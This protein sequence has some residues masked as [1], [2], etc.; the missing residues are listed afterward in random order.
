[1]AIEHELRDRQ[2]TPWTRRL[3]PVREYVATENASAAILL[4]ATIAA[5]VWANSPWSDSYERLWDTEVSLQ[6]R[7]APS[8][9]STCASGST[10]GSW[11]SSS[12]S[13][14]SRSAASST[15]ASCASGAASPPRCW[16][17]SAAWSLPALIYL[18]INAGE[19]SVAGLGHRH[20][21]RHRL[22]PRRP[23]A[24]GRGRSPGC[25]VP[26][27]VGDRRRHR[28]ADRHRAG[29]HRRPVV[30]RPGR[31]ARALRRRAGDA[32]QP[33]SATASRT[34]WSGSGMWL[35]MLASGVHPTIAGVAVGVLAT[36]YP[37]SRAGPARAGAFWRL[38]REQPTPQ[39]A[40]DRQ[41]HPGVDGLAQRAA[42]APVPPVDELS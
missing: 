14:G 11:R 15:W 12:S 36:A 17:R 38:F 19:P 22:R 41:P 13:S 30:S 35:A 3:A 37:P 27:D 20:G 16:R 33:V 42:A 6:L 10:T 21:H 5:L 26:A 4:A 32:T 18:A 39:Y 29:L 28:G 25:G 2:V 8:S 40:R 23:R 1:M 7:R 34:S 31:R 24:R 9:R